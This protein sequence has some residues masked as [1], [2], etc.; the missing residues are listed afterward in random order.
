MEKRPIFDVLPNDRTVFVGLLEATIRRYGWLCHAYCLMGNHFHLAVETPRANIGNGMRYLKS[1]YAMWF[2]DEATR[3]GA[4]FERRYFGEIVKTEAYAFELLRYIV[5]NPVR[6]HLC[7]HPGDWKWSSYCAV[8]G[9]APAPRF[10]HVAG[11]HQLFGEGAR[12]ISLYERFVDD[13]VALIAA[14]DAELARL[15]MSGV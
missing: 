4:L 10:L 11:T 9:R 1:R 5:L 8:T 15:A 3:V 6:A 13:G 14:R 2:N 7:A 12:G